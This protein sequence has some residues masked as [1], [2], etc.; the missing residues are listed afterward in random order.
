VAAPPT[1]FT[2][3]AE[4]QEPGKEELLQFVDAVLDFLNFVIEHPNEFGFLWQGHPELRLL[5][6]ETFRGDVVEIGGPELRD[7]I[8]QIDNQTLRSHGLSGRALRF[9]LKVVDS[10]ASMWGAAKGLGIPGWLKRIIEAIDA[11]LGSLVE[12]AHAGGIIKEFKDALSAL[13]PEQKEK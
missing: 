1:W 10:I 6:R 9:K 5:A 3:I 2:D 7:A 8:P 13:V 4:A 11:I 12:A